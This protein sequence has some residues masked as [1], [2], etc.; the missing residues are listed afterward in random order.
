VLADD[1]FYRERAFGGGISASSASVPFFSV[2]FLVFLFGGMLCRVDSLRYHASFS[3]S[4]FCFQLRP[5][6]S[7]RTLDISPSPHRTFTS[8]MC[9]FVL[10]TSVLVM[11]PLQSAFFSPSVPPCPKLA[12]HNSFT[13]NLAFCNFPFLPYRTSPS[14]DSSQSVS[15]NG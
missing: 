8:L 1:I 5:S 3:S 13:P 11:F 12:D 10:P 15:P 2:P 6:Q 9:P 4:F 14:P 7:D